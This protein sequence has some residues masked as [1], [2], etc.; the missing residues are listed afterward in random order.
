MKANGTF[1]FVTMGASARAAD[2]L[3]TAIAEW[4]AWQQAG[5]LLQAAAN[6]TTKGN[7]CRGDRPSR[8]RAVSVLPGRAVDAM[9][10]RG[11]SVLFPARWGK[12]PIPIKLV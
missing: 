9:I 1:A 4:Q 2:A 6:E 3:P 5:K 10:P 7:D 8:A 12:T 11:P